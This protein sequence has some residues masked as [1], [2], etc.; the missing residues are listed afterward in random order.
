MQISRPFPARANLPTCV[1]STNLTPLRAKY[2]SH[3]PC[4][5]HTNHSHAHWVPNTN[6]TPLLTPLACQISINHTPIAC[7]IP[8]GVLYR[9]LLRHCIPTHLCDSTCINS[10]A[11]KLVGKKRVSCAYLGIRCV[12]TVPPA[13]TDPCRATRL[14]RA[15]VGI[16]CED[17]TLWA[18]TLRQPCVNL[19][20]TLRLPYVYLTSTLRLPCVHLAS[21]L[22]PPCVHLASTLRPPC[23]H[24]AIMSNYTWVNLT[25][26]N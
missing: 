3:A 17:T 22:R 25:F 18:S 1:P 19:A 13:S 24:L 9:M 4:V 5:P 12:D 2:Q 10:C 26:P 23:V 6:L 21:T 16:R 20:S 14:S 7:Q 11:Y 8:V 15:Y